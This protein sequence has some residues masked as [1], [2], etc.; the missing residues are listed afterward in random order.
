M[1][2]KRKKKKLIKT[3]L[4]NM[5]MQFIPEDLWFLK[6]PLKA[7]KMIKVPSSLKF[8]A[9]KSTK[10][11]AKALAKGLVRGTQR[12]RKN[13]FAFAIL[14]SI[15]SGI[16]GSFLGYNAAI[17]GKKETNYLSSFSSSSVSGATTYLNNKN[18]R[19]CFTPG[20]ACL[21]LIL[22]EI[23]KAKSTIFLQAYSMTSK[24][25]SEAL[26]MAK[27]RNV[28][29]FVLLDKSQEKDT[30]SSTFYMAQNG[31]CIKIDYRPAIAHNKVIIID[32]K[33]T[34]TGSY[35]W[36]N[37][38][39]KR[40]AENLLIIDQHDIANRYLQNFKKRWALARDYHQPSQKLNFFS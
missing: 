30:R 6:L 4:I 7:L 13:L 29:I 38:A 39:E 32:S 37:A 10:G 16:L 2:F 34:L 20:E 36:T 18:L 17:S 11:S 35:N 9:I 23:H 5:I 40:N 26:V 31:L 27:K 14:G 21:P 25:I 19:M 28:E 22:E 8:N 3:S 24:P 12:R 1:S 33:V 15:G